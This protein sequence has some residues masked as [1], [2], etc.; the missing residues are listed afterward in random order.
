MAWIGGLAIGLLREFGALG[1]LVV[2][3]LAVPF[4]GRDEARPFGHA[5]CRQLLGLLAI[6]V[7][8]VLLVHVGM[9]SFL[10][11]QAFFGATFR[12]ATGPV[13][14]VGLCRNV[15]PLL[16]GFVA[17]GLIGTRLVTELRCHCRLDID[18][19]PNWSP[20]REVLRGRIADDLGPARPSRLVAVRLTAALIAGPIYC[21]AGAT[22]GIVTG[23]LVS[24][25]M[26][27]MGASDFFGLFWD[28]LWVR[29]IVG[30]V[31]KGA[32]FSGLAALLACREGLRHEQERLETE[33]QTTTEPESRTNASERTE[34]NG[35]S[36][37]LCPPWARMEAV[38]WSVFRA[39]AMAVM[40]QLFL[41]GSWFVLL[42]LSGPPFG[43][44][45]MIPARP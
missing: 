29:D 35:S 13:V 12:T 37:P 9:G 38:S 33:A 25:S 4:Q 24:A 34:S 23:Y 16:S 19:D 10:A 41:N 21:I 2:G 22:S 42:Y 30:M 44:T 31:V 1:T 14:G 27:G 17:A 36:A 28:M 18:L 20:D 26:F 39:I 45:V 7:P 5:V 32:V 6:G 15:A 11:M 40:L 43:P 3:A 8:L